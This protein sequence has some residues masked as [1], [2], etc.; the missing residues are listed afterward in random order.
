MSDFSNRVDDILE[1]VSKSE[2][3]REALIFSLTRNA[4]QKALLDMVGMIEDAKKTFQMDENDFDIK[5]YNKI[6]Q[7]ISE[8]SYVVVDAKIKTLDTAS[9][10]RIPESVDKW[11]HVAKEVRKIV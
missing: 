9:A 11:I 6:N 5:N 4:R 7:L 10:D 1:E 8:G 2:E 3:K